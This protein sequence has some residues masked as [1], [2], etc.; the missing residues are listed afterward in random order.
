M[1]LDRDAFAR[2]VAA[3][4]WPPVTL[5][6]RVIRG[7]ADWSAVLTGTPSLSVLERVTLLRSQLWRRLLVLTPTG[8]QHLREWIDEER[9][10]PRALETRCERFDRLGR[11]LPYFADDSKWEL[12]VETLVGLPRPVSDCIARTCYVA[13]L[14]PRLVGW[15][16]GPLPLRNPIFIDGKQS[17][18]EIV[19]T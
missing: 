15:T 12:V 7:A 3:L 2:L 5:G 14:G 4:G 17:D 10:M 8:R 1:T 9:V 16:S 11:E 13:A 19:Q 18:A 6:P